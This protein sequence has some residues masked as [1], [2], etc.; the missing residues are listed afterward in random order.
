MIVPR[1]SNAPHNGEASRNS[2]DSFHDA[3]TLATYRAQHV[4]SRYAL[5]FETAALVAALALG[6]E[7]DD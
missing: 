5:P 3:L 2:L 7:H 6:G 4:S 1:N